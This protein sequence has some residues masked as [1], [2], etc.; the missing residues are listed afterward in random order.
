MF[1]QPLS[2]LLPTVVGIELRGS[3]PEGSTATDLVLTVAQL[4]RRHGVVGKFVEFYG[5]GVERVPVENRATI[6]NM[7]PEYGSTCT[8]FPI[9]DET[10]RYLRATGRPD[11]SRRARGG[12]R[13]GTGV[14]ARPRGATRLRRNARAR[15]VDGR[16]VVGG[17]GATAGPRRARRRAHGVPKGVARVPPTIRPG[18]AR[19][20]DR[21]EAR[22]RRGGIGQ[23]VPCQRS[24]RGRAS[25][26]RNR[27]TRPGRRT[28]C[29]RSRGR[30]VPHAVSGH[31]PTTARTFAITDGDVV[32]AAITS[33]TNTSNPSVMIAAGL[34]AKK[35]VELVS[36]CR[37]G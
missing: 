35:A 20:A 23:L 27:P 16:T 21:C 5:E 10:L 36:P 31:A 7:S 17:S 30:S 32:I 11:G 29:A 26:H 37:R 1:G 13:E 33:C 4:L 12:I 9:D 22:N 18:C 6:G 14:V 25:C 2:L 8:M 24:R 34:L 3:L 28:R 15:S 19:G